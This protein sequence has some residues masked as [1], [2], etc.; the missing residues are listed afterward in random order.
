[1]SQ[2]KSSKFFDF[3]KESDFWREV[4]INVVSGVLLAG[5][6]FCAAQTPLVL[7]KLK[8]IAVQLSTA[9]N[10][11]SVVLPLAEKSYQNGDFK[12]VLAVSQDVMGVVPDKN[13]QRVVDLRKNAAQKL[14][15]VYAAGTEEKTKSVQV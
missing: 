2:P 8:E 3:F 9:A 15:L 14:N 11:P 10:D 7:G 5:L 6:T 13:F 4:S 1:M 12:N